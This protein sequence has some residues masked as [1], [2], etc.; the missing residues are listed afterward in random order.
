MTVE[1]TADGDA[2]RSVLPALAT[3]VAAGLG[4]VVVLRSFDRHLPRLDPTAGEAVLLVA[5]SVLVLLLVLGLH[6]AGHL[7]G[8]RVAGFRPLLFVVG[9]LKLERRDGRWR[10][11]LNRNLALYGGLAVSAPTDTR[12]LRRRTLLYVAAG[13]AASLAIG[14]LV[15]LLLTAS[16]AG[17]ADSGAP[18]PEAA[19]STWSLVF[20]AGSLAIGLVTLI[21]GRTVGFDTDGGRI[22]RLARGGL[23]AEGEVAVLALVGLSYGGRRPRSWDPD[24]VD[25]ALRADPGSP[26]GVAARQMAYVH[27]LDRGETEEARRHLEAALAARENL[28]P[29]TRPAL[30]LQAAYFAAVHDGKPVRARIWLDRAEGGMLVSPHERPLAEGAVRR[31]EGEGEEALALLHRAREEL[32]RALDRGRARAEAEWTAELEDAVRADARSDSTGR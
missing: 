22:L 1:N 13:P 14:G 17:P 12:D 25:R 9:P 15:L 23:A 8:G 19:A 21:P 4:V 18:F 20:G 30:Y 29:P 7:L 27:A 31:A 10:A 26:P 28:P 16:G 6:E 2:D 3:A 11:R 24:L 5:G 32:P